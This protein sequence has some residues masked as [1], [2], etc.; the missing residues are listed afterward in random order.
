MNQRLKTQ[1][2]LIVL[3]LATVAGTSALMW[4]VRRADA[5]SLV[6]Q[7][8]PSAEAQV[9][10]YRSVR[11][12]L[13]PFSAKI[14]YFG[15]LRIQYTVCGKSYRV[16]YPMGTYSESESELLP[17]L[18]HEK[19]SGHYMVHYDAKNPANGYAYKVEVR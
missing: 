16:W 17:R 15:E 4:W 13:H 5:V 7:S 18:E 3:T 6:R 2:P 19:V 10:G 12:D 1:L 8:W 9:I 11:R 14:L